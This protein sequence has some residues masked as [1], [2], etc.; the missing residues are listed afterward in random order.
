MKNILR[1]SVFALAA[2]LASCST[3]D[4]FDETPVAG[5]KAGTEAAISEMPLAEESRSALA[6]DNGSMLFTWNNG[7][8]IAIYPKFISAEVQRFPDADASPQVVYTYVSGGDTPQQRGVVI[9]AFGVTEE[10]S[11]KLDIEGSHNFYAWYPY[12]SEGPLAAPELGYRHMPVDYEG[13]VQSKNVEIAYYQKDDE[14]YLAS[15]R[16]ASA[17]L[18]QYDYMAAE[19]EQGEDLYT[20]FG[21]NHLQATVRFYMKV[22]NPDLDQTFDSLLLF[23]KNDGGLEQYNF[24]SKGYYDMQEMDFITE[25]DE[26]KLEQPAMLKLK[27]GEEGFDLIDREANSS[28]YGKTSD[29]YKRGDNYILI[30]YMAVAPVNLTL[31]AHPKPILYLCAH[32]GTGDDMVKRY[33]KATLSK[34]NI[35]AGYLYQWSSSTNEEQPIT[36]EELEVE[37]WKEEVGYINTVVGDDGSK[38][39]GAGTE[40]W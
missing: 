3:E 35:E 25:D 22:P 8:K 4:V 24:V 30:A 9:G 31:D 40:N 12:R 37:E 13:Q 28:R 27:L 2:V 26:Y 17:H 10:E 23:R 16:T 5:I 38:I 20:Y 39:P 21:F 6:Y 7:D 18:A 29:L 1:F 36:F 19:A 32:T 14:K 11:T 15:E 34:K 33:Y